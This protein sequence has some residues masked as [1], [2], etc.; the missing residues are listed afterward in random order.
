MAMSEP[1]PSPEPP[2]PDGESVAP[3]LAATVIL[4]RDG[5]GGLEVLLV[6]RTPQAR[7]MAG[8]W[9]F[10]GGAMD[11]GDGPGQA[12]LRAAA[13]RELHE[14]AGIVL[15]PDPELVVF[16][17]WITPE[18]VT[19]RYDT[20]FYLASCPPDQ[21]PRVD[22]HEIVDARWLTAADALD[23]A[24]RGEIEI[25]FPTR[26]QLQR[27]TAFTSVEELLTVARDAPVHPVRP[28]IIGSGE[29]A[30]I[31]LPGEP[32]YDDWS[33]GQTECGGVR[34]GC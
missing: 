15:G 1:G 21:S 4:V 12:G 8:A 22:G 26:K 18:R 5:G 28:R 33:G 32:G 17:H 24:R 14:E 3:R 13:A 6:R 25:A 2:V 29:L 30:R 9:V 11:P 27:L 34:S 31:V 7:F 19:I 20:W 10:P 16:S 23:G